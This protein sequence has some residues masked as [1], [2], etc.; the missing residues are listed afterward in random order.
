MKLEER[1]RSRRIARCRIGR[2]MQQQDTVVPLLGR[3]RVVVAPGSDVFG[4]IVLAML[5]AMGSLAETALPSRRP[6]ELKFRSRRV[7]RLP[8]G[9]R[10]EN[11]PE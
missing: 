4:R 10:R 7:G 8:C 2:D 5:E 9:G 11:I 3:N 6:R 1:C